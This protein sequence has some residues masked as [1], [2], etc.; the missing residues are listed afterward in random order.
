MGDETSIYWL[1][2]VTATLWVLLD[3][4]ISNKWVELSV[5]VATNQ[6]I[7]YVATALFG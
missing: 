5:K 6:V 3:I 4:K 2:W 7:L 1:Y